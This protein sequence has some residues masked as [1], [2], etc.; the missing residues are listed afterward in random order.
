M[1]RFAEDLYSHFLKLLT[2]C[3][4]LMQWIKNR[5]HSHLWE[6][7]KMQGKDYWPGNQKSLS[8]LALKNLF[9]SI[10]MQTWMLILTF[11]LLFWEGK[12][13]GHW[14]KAHLPPTKFVLSQDNCSHIII[15]IWI[16]N[17][18]NQF[19][20]LIMVIIKIIRIFYEN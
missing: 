18:L 17:L 16:Q 5:N 1:P 10:Q 15:L 7:I 20:K 4:R 2:Y 6:T 12:E 19:P 9:Q 8:G 3:L 11:F 14:I 13:H